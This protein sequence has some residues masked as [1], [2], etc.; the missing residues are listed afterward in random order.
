MPRRHTCCACLL[1]LTLVGASPAT[2]PAAD[3]PAA[4]G[5]LADPDPAVRDATLEQL[6]ALPADAL[7]A[8]SAAARAAGPLRPDQVAAL[9][10][11]VCQVFLAPEPYEVAGGMDGPR[12]IVGQNWPYGFGYDPRLGVPV[13]DR[14]VGFPG[15]RVLRDGDLILGLYSDPALGAEKPPD[16]ETH[17]RRELVAAMRAC[18]TRPQVTLSVLRLGTIRRLTV[19]MADEPA[20][21]VGR[22][23]ARMDAF[24]RDRRDRAE[25]YW[26]DHFAPGEPVAALELDGGPD[27]HGTGP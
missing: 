25:A 15:R 27:G 13:L 21:T 19:T 14:W 10:E 17:D 9:H 16:L 8:L 6:M 5:R 23:S 20:D 18:P 12:Y 22:Y 24:L 26:R 7:P 1:A 11:V 4:L 3:L 2:G